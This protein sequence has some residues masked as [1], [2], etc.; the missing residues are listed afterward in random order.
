M[1]NF[2]VG[3]HEAPSLPPACSTLPWPQALLRKKKKIW[4]LQTTSPFK[5]IRKEV[6]EEVR[7][8]T[9]DLN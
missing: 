7:T 3:R 8:Q 1:R 6:E 4:S 9:A 2:F 5:Q